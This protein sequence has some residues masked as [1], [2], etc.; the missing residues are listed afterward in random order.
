M[1]LYQYIES[2]VFLKF[3]SGSYSLKICHCY[4]HVVYTLTCWNYVIPLYLYITSS[5]HLCYWGI[6]FVHQYHGCNSGG[7]YYFANN[8]SVV[9]L[10]T[11]VHYAYMCLE[12]LLPFINMWVVQ[13]AHWEVLLLHNVCVFNFNNNMVIYFCIKSI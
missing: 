5:M 4:L 9:L 3:A 13:G 6:L 2:F 7:T 1:H 8:Y 11:A 12:D 10:I